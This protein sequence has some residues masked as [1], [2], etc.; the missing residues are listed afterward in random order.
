MSIINYMKVIEFPDMRIEMRDG[1]V[2]SARVWLP[3]NATFHPVPAI[4]EHLP[5]R[6]RDGTVNRDN[7]NHTW[8]AKNGYACVRTDMRG[9]GDSEGHMADEYLQQE[10][11]DAIDVIGWLV[12]QNW[13]SGNVGMMGISWGGFNSLQVASMN[14]DSLKA[15][16][17]VC[18]SVDRFADDIHYKGGCLLGVNFTWAARMLSYSSRP[19]DPKIFGSGWRNEWLNRLKNIPLLADKWLL[20]Q[21]Q[22][23]YWKHGS[24]CEDYK[25]I[26][27]AV[28][29]VGGWHDGYRNTVEKLVSNLDAPVKGIVGP[30]NHRYPHLAEPEPKIGFLQE[31]L[32]WW[33]KWLK[34]I[35]NGVENN[36]DYRLFIMDSIEPKRKLTSRSGRW[37]NLPL[38]SPGAISLNTVF[39]GDGVLSDVEMIFKKDLKVNSPI[40]V[41]FATGEFFPYNFGPELPAEQSLDDAKSLCFNGAILT[42]AKNIIGAPTVKLLISSNKPLAQLAVRLCDLRPNG[43]SALISHGFINLTMNGSFENPRHLT[44]DQKFKVNLQLDQ[45]AYFLPE[46]HR[47]RLA[48][49]NCYWPFV[50]PSPEIGTINIF[51]GK[52]VIPEMSENTIAEQYVFDDPITG[53]LWNCE[54][55]RASSSTREEFFDEISGEKIIEVKHDSGSTLDLEH[56]LE[57]DSSVV[58]RWFIK[59]NDPLSA[60]SEVNWHQSMKR[61]KWSID[62]YSSLKVTCSSSSFFLTASI[63]AYEGKELVFSRNFEETV[64]RKFI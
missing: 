13:C 55:K 3:E 40:D 64:D 42:R 6:K 18:S 37:I 35:D 1:C 17:T 44:V 33:D 59:D 11:D 50:W 32:R 58:E 8:F 21:R 61:A 12:K 46:G 16:V 27:A 39:L 47:L 49:S 19:P 14:P 23:D 9:N 15:I 36:P 60:K 26:N 52:L 34:N 30:W 62:T 28:L 20:E 25:S 63:E 2:L 43:T 54:E 31:S 53:D 7:L 57:T 56:G 29:A 24:V 41:G 4:L 48:I 45:I 51:S 10:L 38:D 22:S 5:Y